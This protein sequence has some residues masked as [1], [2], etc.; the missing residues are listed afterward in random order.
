MRL[1]DQICRGLLFQKAYPE[2][3][4]SFAVQKK[5]VGV[6]GDSQGNR[7]RLLFT[8]LAQ[9]YPVEF[10]EI[11]S[12][13]DETLDGL[14]VL[15]GQIL[16]GKAA[17]IRGIP[18]C[19]VVADIAGATQAAGPEVRFGTSDCLDIALRGQTMTETG[20]GAVPVLSLETGDE[21]LASKGGQPV[22][23]SRP[24]GT[25]RCQLITVPPPALAQGELLFKHL[26][27]GRFL[28][29][30]P[31]INFLRRI[32]ADIDWQDA[33][34][35]T[36]FVFDDPSLYWPSYGFVD[37]R[38]L[39]ELAANQGLF[40]SV[41]TIP[42]DTWW[43]NGSVAATFR[44]SSP[45]LSVIMHGNNH[46]ADEMLGER[47]SDDHLQIAAQAMRRIE[48]LERYGLSGFR[49]MEA[50]HGAISNGMMSHLMSLGY[51]AVLCTTELLLYHNSNVTWP[52][53]LGLDRAEFLGGGMP[54]ISRVKMKANWKN[55]VILSAFLRKPFV[56]AGHHW[57]AA[58]RFQLLKEIAGLINGLRLLA[59]SSPL[60]MVRGNYKHLQRGHELKVKMYARTIRVPVPEGVTQLFVHRP[61]FQSHGQME[62]LEVASPSGEIFKENGNSII[63]PI[64]VRSGD[65]LEIRSLP[66]RPID[67]RTVRTPRA[68]GWPFF[69]KFLM[70][71]RDRSSPMRYQASRLIHGAKA[72]VPG[73]K[74]DY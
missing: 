62:M 7:Y 67:F 71:L 29:L 52:A 47:G 53:T 35:Q 28:G 4:L 31:L 60:D 54:T 1:A 66:S 25:S 2:T 41:A 26:S 57:D 45:R 39:A 10:R 9:L 13:K 18:A 63:G 50:P 70:E 27:G 51:E 42:L 64:T 19:V 3:Q 33:P 73:K 48:R 24:V 6:L 74:E 43:V 69:R 59:W 32:V 55:E 68:D 37:Y 12:V 8:T 65:V 38:L 21:V 11:V 61:W 44:S 36:C 14:I 46:T 40:V 56:I 30:L 22:W 23:L 16:E 72:K 58:D 17:A 20:T 15:N 34:V 5:I 49:I